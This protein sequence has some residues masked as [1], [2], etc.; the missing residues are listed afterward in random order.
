MAVVTQKLDQMLKTSAIEADPA[1]TF[2]ARDYPTLNGTRSIYRRFSRQ[3]CTGNYAHCNYFEWFLFHPSAPMLSY[4]V[5]F[6]LVIQQP[7]ATRVR[8]A[9][10]PSRPTS[11]RVPQRSR[12]VLLD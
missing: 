10:G 8:L 11:S 1:A 6:D 12:V 9:A 4:S 2:P 5:H 7:G 3:V